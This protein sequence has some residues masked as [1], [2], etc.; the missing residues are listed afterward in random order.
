MSDTATISKANEFLS[1]P[2]QMLIGGNWVEAVS[3]ETIAVEDPATGKLIGYVAAAGRDDV[4]SAVR[5]ARASFEARVWQGMPGEQRAAIMWKLADLIEANMPELIH[6]E[7][8]D[9]GMP[10]AFAQAT[11]GGAASG[12]RY[13]AGMCTK[14]YGRTTTM[15]ADME[16]HA[17][18]LSEPVGVVGLITPWNGPIATLF[19]K[20]APALAAGCSVVVKPA[21]LTSL[22]ALRVGALALEAGVPPGVVNIVTG[23]GTV[24]GAALVEHPGV[25]KISFTGSTAVGKSIVAAAA[26]NLKRVTLELGGK[27]PVFVFD[28]ADL[29]AAIPA[30]A[31]GIFANSGQVCFAGSRLYVQPKVYDKVVAGIE[32]FAKS[33]TLGSGLDT[34]NRLGPLISNRQRE[35]VLSYIES[36]LAEGAELVTGGKTHGD[37]GYFIE[38]TIFAGATPDMKIVQEEI[39]GP[40]LSVMLFDDIAEVAKLGNATSYGLGA[41]VYTRDIGNA[42][43]AARLLDAGNIW[44]NCY[45]RTDKSLPFGGFKQSGWGRENGPEGIDAFLEKKAVYIK[46]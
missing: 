43:K 11:I 21:E 39:F 36:G 2:R 28:D 27:S 5:A 25:D 22:T 4:D 32:A 24:A 26:G 1:T 20:L 42:H 30:A 34:A 18:S 12:L 23:L 40:V 35:R 8:L 31:M 3:G 46:L 10:T 33:L 9:N 15:G 37:A 29:D 14:L 41:G 38:P 19:T 44:V 16:F 45:G 17:Y 6:L 13:Y 7:V